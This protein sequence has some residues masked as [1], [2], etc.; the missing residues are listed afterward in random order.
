MLSIVIPFY[1]EEAR[2]KSGKNLSQAVDFMTST[3]NEELELILVD[4]GS[5]DGTLGVLN[6]IKKKY[7]RIPIG[8]INYSPNRGKG[9]A[10]KKGVFECAGNK[11]IVMDADF[12]IDLGEIKKFVDALDE[13]DIVIGTKKHLLSQTLGGQKAPRRILGKGFTFLTNLLLGL[14][15][16][17]ITCGFKGFRSEVGK[18]LFRQQRIDRWSYDSE[19]LFI[20]KKF[21]YSIKELPVSWHHVEGSRVSILTDTTRSFRDLISILLNNYYGK[22]DQ[23]T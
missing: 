20:A 6:K 5:K 18:K 3:L 13:Y 4:D 21:G 14:G 7:S 8:I 23:K 10:V 11:I 2:L 1:N 12:S 15:F 16:T 17:D 22:Y 9:H 19:T